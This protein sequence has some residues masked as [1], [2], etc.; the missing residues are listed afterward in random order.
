MPSTR[1]TRLRLF[2]FHADFAVPA[3]STFIERP[4]SPLPVAAFDSRS[5]GTLNGQR[6]E[7]EEPPPA[8]TA[9]YL[10]AIG[11]RLMLRLQYFNR[12]GTETL[13]TVQTVNAGIIPP[14]G[15]APTIAEYQSRHPL[16]CVA[17]N[18]PGRE[19]VGPGPGNLFARHDGTLDGQLSGRQRRESGGR[20]L[21][22]QL[23]R[24]PFHCLCRKAAG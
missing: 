15:Q 12:G 2:D 11:D 7:I 24:F 20:L 9:D 13:T 23:E 18:Q 3:N 22:L 10:N 8:T 1:L 17:K 21:D 6:N 19:L 5:P 4:E 16:V 14:P